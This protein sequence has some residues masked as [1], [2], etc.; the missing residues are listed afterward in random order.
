M[1][2]VIKILSISLIAFAIALIVV[3]VYY[4]EKLEKAYKWKRYDM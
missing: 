4:T 1:L 2:V 3:I